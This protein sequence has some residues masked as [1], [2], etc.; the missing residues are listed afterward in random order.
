MSQSHIVCGAGVN[1]YINGKLFASVYEFSYDVQTPHADIRAVDCLLPY[2]LASTIVKV[3][4]SFKVYR[5]RRTGGFEGQGVIPKY[6]NL[7]REKY[8]TL[9]VLDQVTGAPLFR[10]DQCVAEHQNWGVAAKAFMTGS[11]SFSGMIALN[12]AY[13]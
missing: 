9:M 13:Q 6:Q 12:E 11:L 2:E 5:L 8:M 10:A 3:T 7:P 4:G 1:L